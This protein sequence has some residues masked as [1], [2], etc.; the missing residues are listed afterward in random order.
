MLPFLVSVPK[1]RRVVAAVVLTGV[2]VV[3]L[4]VVAIAQ[5]IGDPSV[6]S[7]AVA[8]VED[9]PD[10]EITTEEFDRGLKQAARAQ[11]VTRVPEPSD[12]QYEA[13]RDATMS[14]LLQGRWLRGEASERGISVSESEITN[15]LEQLIEEEFGGQKSFD[16][17][18]KQAGFTPEEARVRVELL[19]L[20]EQLQTAVIP[21]SPSVSDSEIEE[22]YD[23]NQVQFGQPELRDV[24]QIVNE[25]RAKVEE[26][27]SLLEQDDSP[28]SW[29]KVAARFSTENA[30]KDIGGVVKGVSTEQREPAIA[31][32]IF[33]AEQGQLVGPAEGQENFYLIQ[34]EKITPAQTTPFAEVAEQIQQ[35]LVQGKEQEI[36]QRFQQDF[37]EKWTSRSFCADDYVVNLCENFTAPVQPIPGAAPVT[38]RGAVQPG[39]ATVFPG[40]PIPAFPQ[41]PCGFQ[42][43]SLDPPEL[44]DWPHAAAGQQGV[45]GPG[46]VPVPPGGA[47][48]APVP[49]AP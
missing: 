2:L 18:L 5:G 23:A 48:P 37:T 4:V 25:D 21:G 8:L 6:P 47:P 26:A 10:G 41:R 20:S 24:R 32:A 22:F 7:G 19:V 49:T 17:Y 38:P 12:P 33:T 43:L 44:C 15:R 1:D 9:A 34:V 35:Q 40:Q 29:E 13:L 45:I 3:L 36:V 28:K 42:D 27:K 31:D 39:R 11:Q 16:R 30:T 14:D 46:G